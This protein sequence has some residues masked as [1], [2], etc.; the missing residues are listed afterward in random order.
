VDNLHN[1]LFP[2]RSVIVAEYFKNISNSQRRLAIVKTPYVYPA[3]CV[4]CKALK[5]CSALNGF[6][7]EETYYPKNLDLKE[8]CNV[9]E[10]FGSRIEKLVFGNGRTFRD[11]PQCRGNILSTLIH[12]HYN[13]SKSHCSNFSLF[14]EIV[15]QY[16]CLFYGSDSSQYRNYCV[17]QEDVSAPNPQD[18]IIAPRPPCRSFCVQVGS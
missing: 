10:A 11:T 3:Q 7:I 4:G 5:S 14:V 1:F 16:L 8:T 17:Y 18:R 2:N 15:M 9:I 12:S 6:Q 13:C